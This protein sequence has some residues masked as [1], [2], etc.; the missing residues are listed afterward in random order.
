M[1]RGSHRVPS[2]DPGLTPSAGAKSKG[3]FGLEGQ[4]P[5]SPTSCPLVF[6]TPLEMKIQLRGV[7][8]ILCNA[9]KY[10]FERVKSGNV[11]CMLHFFNCQGKAYF[12]IL[13]NMRPCLIFQQPSQC[14]NA[15]S[16][17]HVSL[18]NFYQ[19]HRSD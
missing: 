11:V 13:A 8:L 12:C 4:G 7:L 1:S 17:S 14:K 18:E 6:L 3:R 10:I 9:D 19:K 16:N 15:L 5:N 2:G